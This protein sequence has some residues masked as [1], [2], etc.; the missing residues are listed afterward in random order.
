MIYSYH[1]CESFEDQHFNSLSE[2]AL[3]PLR[4]T[5]GSELIHHPIHSTSHPIAASLFALCSLSACGGVCSAIK[6]P[7]KTILDVLP[8][9]SERQT[10]LFSATLPSALPSLGAITKPSPVHC[11]VSSDE[12][13]LVATLDQRYVFVPQKVKE[14]YLVYL[15]K[16][17]ELAD[18]SCIIF[19]STRRGMCVLHL[20]FLSLLSIS[21]CCTRHC[22]L[23][24]QPTKGSTIQISL[25]RLFTL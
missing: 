20:L 13:A 25:C 18:Q 7:L 5:L 8:A 3:V 22:A 24:S 9:V 12:H 4:I 16:H 2:T 6:Q 11:H 1:A 19:T 21:I 23:M 14:C 17:T 15:L 10:L